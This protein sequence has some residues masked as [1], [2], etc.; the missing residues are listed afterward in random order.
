M[1]GIM[2]LN[3]ITTPI[4]SFGWNNWCLLLILPIIL[5]IYLIWFW[6]VN[7]DLRRACKWCT[8][9]LALLIGSLTLGAAI[10]AN[11]NVREER[12]YQ[13]VLD[14]NVNMEQF[15]EDY[16]IIKQVGITYM[17]KEK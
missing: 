9:G 14:S 10:C 7:R 6:Y 4:Y 1:D 13:V 8:I 3:T 11:E 15:R 12:V 5:A 16:E 2:V 17:I